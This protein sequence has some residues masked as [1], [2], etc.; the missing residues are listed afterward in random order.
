[1]GSPYYV[2]KQ[3]NRI[4]VVRS[5]RG[6]EKILELVARSMG[7]NLYSVLRGG[8]GSERVVLDDL[9]D[10]YNKANSSRSRSIVYLEA[11]YDWLGWEKFPRVIIFDF[12][13]KVGKEFTDRWT[14]RFEDGDI[15]LSPLD[16][17]DL[18][19]KTS[20]SMAVSPPQSGQ[21]LNT[22]QTKTFVRMLKDIFFEP[23]GGGV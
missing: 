21:F 8:V 23:D 3:V 6:F 7:T 2:H 10:A 19:V 1:M 12:S 18:S 16:Q 15:C 20:S 13:G 5:F 4:H 9:L 22:N 11:R 17:G 14:A